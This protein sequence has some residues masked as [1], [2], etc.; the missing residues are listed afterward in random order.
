MVAFMKSK[1]K[2]ELNDEIVHLKNQISNLETQLNKYKE[3][4]KDLYLIK[5]SKSEKLFEIVL[6]EF[7]FDVLGKRISE[8]DII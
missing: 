4:I 8:N 7:F 1:T 3:T 2:K 5:K 6:S